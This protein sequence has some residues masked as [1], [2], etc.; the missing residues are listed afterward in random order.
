[1]D[2][3][4]MPEYSELYP[5]DYR[6]RVSE[7]VFSNSLCG[8][9]RP[10]HFDGMLTV[11]LKLLQIIRPHR[12]Y[13]GEKDFQQLELV[14]G[15]VR[16][17]FIPVEI[18]GCPIVRERDGLA[19]SSRN[20]RLDSQQR[21]TAG[22]LFRILNRSADTLEARQELQQQ[23][24]EVD[25]VEDVMGRRLAAARLGPTRLIDNVPLD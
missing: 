18:I 6:Y 5:D 1:V 14:R 21:Q 16:A 10:G 15:L 7:T 17:F 11:V 13:F 8:A 2:A 25:Y 4:F 9:H 19:L 20:Q 22:Q 3:A 12:A 23:G 24:F